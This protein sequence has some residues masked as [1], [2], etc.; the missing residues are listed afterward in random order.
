VQT[1]WAEALG[2]SSDW[3]L[4]SPWKG[5]RNRQ[6]ACHSALIP[7]PEAHFKLI[8]GLETNY[9]SLCQGHNT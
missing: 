7:L 3:A 9:T 2:S 8:A 5:L 4:A 6:D 1:L